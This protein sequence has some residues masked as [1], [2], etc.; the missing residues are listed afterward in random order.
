MKKLYIYTVLEKMDREKPDERARIADEESQNDRG[1][2][3]CVCWGCKDGLRIL[4][5]QK[6]GLSVERR[7]GQA[8]LVERGRMHHCN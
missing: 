2:S 1:L 7:E 6:D 4:K 5:R 8:V 3:V